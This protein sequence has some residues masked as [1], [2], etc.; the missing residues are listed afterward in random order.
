MFEPLL[1]PI[2][3]L[4]LDGISW[5][6]VGGETNSRMKFRPNTYEKSV[7]EKLQVS[8]NICI[9]VGFLKVLISILSID[10]LTHLSILAN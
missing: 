8:P 6:A 10:V 1:S 5:V 4:D 9:L 3:Q 7:P 2:P